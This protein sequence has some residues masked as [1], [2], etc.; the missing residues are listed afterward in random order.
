MCCFIKDVNGMWSVLKVS[1]LEAK[2]QFPVFT[3][4]P[5]WLGVVMHAFDPSTSE[6]KASL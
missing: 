6:A 2:F 3:Q 5:F 1:I 4:T